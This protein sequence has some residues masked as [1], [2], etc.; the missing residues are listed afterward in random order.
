MATGSLHVLF[1]TQL[2]VLP[3]NIS[4]Y[5]LFSQSYRDRVTETALCMLWRSKF[6]HGEI[7]NDVEELCMTDDTVYYVDCPTS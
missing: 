1:C 3:H 2:L 5:I 4:L 7:V 6:G